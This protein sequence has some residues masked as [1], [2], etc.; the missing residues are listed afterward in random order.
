MDLFARWIQPPWQR[1]AH[2][3]QL[4]RW[5]LIPHTDLLFNTAVQCDKRRI[6][7]GLISI[8]CKIFTNLKSCTK[9]CYCLTTE[10]HISIEIKP[11]QVRLLSNCTGMLKKSEFRVLFCSVISLYHSYRW[12][13]FNDRKVA[14][15]ETPPKELAYL[16]LYKRD[17]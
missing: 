10:R 13:I 6:C 4:R 9:K 8:Q 2:E 3:A 16:Y 7:T 12:V 1:M 17:V 11:V 5:S 14:Q 15:S